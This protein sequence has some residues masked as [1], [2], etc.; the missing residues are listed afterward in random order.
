MSGVNNHPTLVR[1][2][3]CVELMDRMMERMGVNPGEAVRADGG[4]AWLEAREN[5]F[6]CQNVER[7]S[8]WLECSATTPADFCPNSK[9]FRF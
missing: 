7:C 4:L 2:H 3:N 5:C 8:D 6:Y 1:Y 9:L